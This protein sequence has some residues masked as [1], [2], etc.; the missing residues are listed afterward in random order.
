LAKT[1]Y[2]TYFMILLWVVVFGF[3]SKESVE[4]RGKIMVTELV[5][6]WFSWWGT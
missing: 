3:V 1:G 5:L 6:P 4:F 2:C